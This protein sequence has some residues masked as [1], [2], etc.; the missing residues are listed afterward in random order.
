MHADQIESDVG[1]V[2][3]LLGA[4]FPQWAD[5]SV[6]AVA[7][8]GTDNALYRLGRDLVARLPLRPSAIG[9]IATEH[10][11]LPH[12][13]PLLTLEVPVPVAR[14]E[15]TPAFP[16]PWSVVRWI[17]GVD[18]TTS[19]YSGAAAAVDLA[20]FLAALRAIDPAGGPPP[21]A[22][23][24]RGRPLAERDR[25]TRWAIGEAADLVDPNAVTAGWEAAVEAPPWDRPPV[26]VH[27]DVAS[28]NLLF[29]DG[30]LHAVIDWGC[31]GIGDPACD[32]IIAWETFDDR[33]RQVLRSEME[34]D[35]ATWA[36]GR[37]WALSTAVAELA[38][39]RHTNAFM[40]ARARRQ[41]AAALDG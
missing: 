13:A 36:R 2:R 27:G 26:W 34:V 6:E 39:Y 5:L 32:L 19:R 30:R 4:Q 41:L 21:A 28:G 20:R 16:W 14:G 1:L 22:V 33:S 3:S 8:T 9:S 12:L 29:R 15:P 37:G 40:A 25:W 11:W 35:E 23:T 10:R 17:E 7:S 38:Y 18:A 31:L 24:G